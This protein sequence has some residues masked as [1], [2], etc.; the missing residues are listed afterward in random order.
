MLRFRL[1]VLPGAFVLSGWLWLAPSAASANPAVEARCTELGA[2]CRCSETMDEVNSDVGPHTD[3]AS[4]PDASECWGNGPRANGTGI[5]WGD[6]DEHGNTIAAPSGWGTAGHVLR[7]PGMAGVWGFLPKAAVT[8]S[9]RTLCMRWYQQMPPPYMGTGIQCSVQDARNKMFQLYFGSTPTLF[10][11]EQRSDNSA[12]Q[13]TEYRCGD[14]AGG[15]TNSPVPFVH[16]SDCDTK[17]CRFEYCFDGNIQAGTNLI[18][19]QVYKSLKTGVTSTATTGTAWNPGP[20]NFSPGILGGDWWHKAPSSQSTY[21]GYF[22]IGTWDTDTNQT[23]GAASEIEGG[24]VSAPQPPAAP[25]LL[26]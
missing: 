11:C 26:P 23:I 3:F 25:T 2:N 14:P 6:A 24:S 20:I 17:P 7:V 13:D 10:Q 1:A 18:I 12:C 8:S 21:R 4:S 15:T 19:R 22:M 9:T 5:G 16:N